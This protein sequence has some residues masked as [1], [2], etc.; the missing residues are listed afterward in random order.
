MMLHSREQGNVNASFKL[1]V[2]LFLIKV[3]GR[4]FTQSGGGK[5]GVV[6][7]GWPGE[8]RDAVRSSGNEGNEDD[9][10]VTSCVCQSVRRSVCHNERSLLITVR[11]VVLCTSSSPDHSR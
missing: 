10:G 3:G 9:A 8:C 7:V 2:K 5:D 1:S 11:T 4:I 6:V